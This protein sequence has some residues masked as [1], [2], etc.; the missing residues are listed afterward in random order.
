MS[1]WMS[2]GLQTL[3]VARMLL[4]L[5]LGQG[6]RLKK[7][8]LYRSPPVFMSTLTGCMS[9]GMSLSADPLPVNKKAA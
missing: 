9:Y 1:G 7:K 5:Q 2:I 4:H 3:E 8:H 6:W